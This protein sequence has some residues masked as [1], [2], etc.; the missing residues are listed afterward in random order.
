MR[1]VLATAEKLDIKLILGGALQGLTNVLAYQGS[2]DDARATGERAVAATSAQNDRRF[3]GSA[4]AYLSVTEYLAG[5]YARAEGHA[6]A[7]VTTWE[8]VPSSRPFAIALLARAL[9]AQGRPVEALVSA[10]EA[11]AQLESLGVVDDGEATIR[12]ALAECLVATGDKL[13]AKEVLDKAASRILASAEA[14][15]DPAIRESFL[16]RIPE[17]RRI[18]ELARELAASKS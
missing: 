4:E 12:L 5:D 17:H 10:R 14:I 9:L 11:Y 13:A 6:R 18:L 7:A 3:Q 1:K 8:P 2:F 16:T 15:A